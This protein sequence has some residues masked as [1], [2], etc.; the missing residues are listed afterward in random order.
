[1]KARR[2][3]PFKP[4]FRCL[5][6]AESFKK[7]RDK[8]I[9]AGIVMRRDLIIDGFIF[10]SVTI[11]GDDATNKI[12]EMY[13]RLKRDDIN[14]IMINGCIISW[15]N[16]INVDKIYQNTGIPTICITYEPSPGIEKYLKKYFDEETAQKKIEEYKSLG[17][18]VKIYVKRANKYIYIRS[19]GIDPKVTKEVINAF[20]HNGIMPEPL[21]VAQGLARAMLNFINSVNIKEFY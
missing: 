5:G 4:A 12:I 19:A 2:V 14:V 8:S 11:G 18:R 13:S 21:R 3:N 1:M 7:G 6:I 10:T 9:L 16:M 15:F 20:I 17:E